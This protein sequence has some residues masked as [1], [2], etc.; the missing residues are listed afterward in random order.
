MNRLSFFDNVLYTFRETLKCVN[1]LAH[2]GAS[3]DSVL[4]QPFGDA[5]EVVDL[6]AHAPGCR[7]RT[8]GWEVDQATLESRLR[9]VL[10]VCVLLYVLLEYLLETI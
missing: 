3:D 8:R 9:P 4:G 6:S 10:E 1:E 2:A 5:V 7:V